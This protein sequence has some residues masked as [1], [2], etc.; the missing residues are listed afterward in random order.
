MVAACARGAPDLPL[1]AATSG[2]SAAITLSPAESR[3]TCT[4]ITR[5]RTSVAKEERELEAKIK[6]NREQNQATV[7]LGGVAAGAVLSEHNQAEKKRLDELQQK[8]DRLIV[9]ARQ[10]S[11]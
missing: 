1:D 7:F 6:A 9:I 11:C 2:F 4:D 3:L 10:K 8:R 5:E